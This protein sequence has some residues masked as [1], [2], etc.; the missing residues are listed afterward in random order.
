VKQH[1]RRDRIVLPDLGEVIT[2][3]FETLRADMAQGHS[4]RI[5]AYFAFSAKFHTYSPENKLLIYE[6]CPNATRVAGYRRWIDEGYQV[7]KGER[8]IRIKAPMIKKDPESE[9][10]KRVVGFL[11]VKVF[12]VSQ[13]TPD[14]RPPA[15]FPEVYG[16]FDHL[17]DAMYRAVQQGGVQVV[18]TAHTQGAQG[19]STIG[20][21]A[22]KE[23]MTS[24][25]RCLT[26]LHEWAHEIM[27]N[28]Q[29][30]KELARPVKECHAEATCYIV[31]THFGIP[32]PYSA[33]YL[34]NWG[35]TPETLKE[36]MEIVQ[37]S[38]SHIITRINTVLSST[39]H[40]R[41]GE[42]RE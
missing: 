9:D 23:G 2:Q 39:D 4:E 7:A 17:Y 10:E 34:L 19:Y 27:H 21:I 18:E 42:G 40:R 30:R 8:G 1:I 24:G 13:L 20:R 12:D 41:T 37:R 15:F 28:Q 14:K 26:L 11:E 25:S 29:V 31:A 36:E 32:T 5:L 33:D 38:A 22:L 35:T 6:Q 16:D 3:S